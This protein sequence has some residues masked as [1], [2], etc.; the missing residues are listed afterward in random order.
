MASVYVVKPGLLT[1]VQDRGRWGAQSFGV[2]VSGPMDLY[3]HRLANALAGNDADAATLEVTISGPELEFDDARTVAV[4][5]ALFE[6]TIDDRPIDLRSA[7]EVSAGSVMRFGRRLRGSRA[8]IAVAGGIATPSALGSRSTHLPSGMGGLDG[9]ALRS[10]DRLPLGAPTRATRPVRRSPIPDSSASWALPDG[11]ATLRVLPGPQLDKFLP[12]AW[13][14]L[15]S[16]PYSIATDSN[17]MGYRLVGPSLET[18]GRLDVI[19]DATPTG[20]LQ[21]P[22][23][24]QPILLMADRQTTGGYPKIAAVISADISVAGQL[25]PGDTVTFV[26]CS[27]QEALAALIA[28]ERSLMAASGRP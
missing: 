4:T 14:V 27:P 16:S 25:G 10:G 19:S 24:G 1:T 2:S 15:Q 17:R 8:Y 6:I 28:Q 13:D 26:A 23:S 5:G 22:A 9:R 11:R 3:S 21:V 20:A 18:P 12:T 7:V